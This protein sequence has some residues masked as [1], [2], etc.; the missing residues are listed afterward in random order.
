MDIGTKLINQYFGYLKANGIGGVQIST[1]T[2]GA[3]DFFVKMGFI[4]LFKT[5]LSC[6]KFYLGR[7]IFRYSLGRKL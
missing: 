2:E 3:K 5:K 7:D 1:M 6:L 4:E